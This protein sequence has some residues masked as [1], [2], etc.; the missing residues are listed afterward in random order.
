MDKYFRMFRQEVQL[1]ENNIKNEKDKVLGKVKESLGKVFDDNEMEFQGKM[2]TIKGDIGNK[3]EDIK[4]DVLDKTNDI[5]DN[6]KK[7]KELK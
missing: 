4:E 5:L 7:R 6:M 2:Q 3:L 1:V